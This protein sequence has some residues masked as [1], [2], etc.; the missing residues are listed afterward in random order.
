MSITGI[1]LAG[2]K[3]SRM[4]TEKG[5]IILN[6]KKMMNFPLMALESV[7]D[8][9]LI[10]TC[11]ESF[12]YPEYQV[13]CD[14]IPGLGPIG[15]ILTCLKKSDSELNI[16]LSYDMP[17]VSSELLSYL[18]KHSAGFNITAPSLENQ[19]PEPL[20]AIFHKNTASVI[21]DSI[22]NKNYKVNDLFRQTT[23]NHVIIHSE[24]PFFNPFV[25]YNVNKP[26]E[27]EEI[28]QMI[29]SHHSN[30]GKNHEGNSGE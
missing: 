26:D 3:S 9:I 19:L 8:H 29:K 14:E 24:L 7:C 30:P 21:T 28:N 6:G 23:F 15:G 5:E 13:I 10:S 27:F 2:G 25:F 12:K 1:L 17:F 18:I 11:N 16:V 4:G 20:C 22:R